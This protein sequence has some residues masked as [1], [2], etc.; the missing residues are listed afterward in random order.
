MEEFEVYLNK[1]ITCKNTSLR[2]FVRVNLKK[3]IRQARVDDNPT[4]QIQSYSSRNLNFHQ[5]YYYVCAAD[6]KSLLLY[7][8][9]VMTREKRDII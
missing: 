2:T 5:Y 7:T 1:I 6:N 8:V 9:C 3:T 4:R